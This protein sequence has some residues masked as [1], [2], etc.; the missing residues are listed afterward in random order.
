MVATAGLLW[1]TLGL[2]VRLMDE[3]GPW[4]ILFYRAIVQVVV[5]AAFVAVRNPGSFVRT[6]TGVGYNG[7]LS[8]ASLSFSSI[9]F[10][11]ALTLT[12]VAEAT[13]ILGAAPVMAGALGWMLLREPITRTNWTTM[14][15]AAAGLTVMTYTGTVSGNVAGILLALGGALGFAA[16]SVLQRRG[17]DTDMLPAVLLSGVV[18]LVATGPL[19]GGATISVSDA[20][21]ALYLGGVALAGGLALYTIGSRHVRAGELVL[22]AMTEVVFAPLWVWWILGETMATTTIVGGIMIITAVL[23]QARAREVVPALRGHG[24]SRPIRKATRS[25]H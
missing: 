12:T 2:G 24:R 19:V 6:L 9:S 15:I 16:F 22:I 3:A 25:T 1:S 20:L 5:L 23:I 18:T 11:Y 10:V 13:L 7:L 8:A 4:R 21:L 14:G 17:R